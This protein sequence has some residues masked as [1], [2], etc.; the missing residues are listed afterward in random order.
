MQPIYNRSH[1]E[2]FASRR[3]NSSLT[4]F[5]A[6]TLALFWILMTAR[7]FQSYVL[8]TPFGRTFGVHDDIYISADFART[9]AAGD[10]LRWYPNGPK[11]EGFSSPLFEPITS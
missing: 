3:G 10:G 4:W 9:F 6:V 7:F 5:A 11:V 2:D 8:V 1:S